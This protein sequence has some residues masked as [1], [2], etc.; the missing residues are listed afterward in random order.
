MNGNNL[1]EWKWPEQGK[2]ARPLTL[3]KSD[4]STELSLTSSIVTEDKMKLTSGLEQEKYLGSF[5]LPRGGALF[6]DNSIK[7]YG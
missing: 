5:C 4:L 1:C 2:N 6:I 7:W 3:Y